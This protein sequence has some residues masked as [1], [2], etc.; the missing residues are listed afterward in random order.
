MFVVVAVATRIEG[1][2]T[3]SALVPAFVFH[4]VS[5]AVGWNL[6]SKAAEP[7]YSESAEDTLTST[8]A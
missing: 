3:L 1:F 8:L 4:A 5:S 7:V 2:T 6:L